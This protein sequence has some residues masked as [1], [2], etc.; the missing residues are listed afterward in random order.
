MVDQ[1][2]PADA[3]AALGPPV[4]PGYDP[5]RCRT[6][7]ARIFWAYMQDKWG[8]PRTNPKTGQ[9]VKNPLNVGA[10]PRGK[11]VIVGHGEARPVTAG[12]IPPSHERFTSHFETCPDRAKWKGQKRRGGGAR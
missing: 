2:T 5:D 1:V 4:P 8:A 11:F 9:R 6:C 3:I 12:E 10:D 7:A